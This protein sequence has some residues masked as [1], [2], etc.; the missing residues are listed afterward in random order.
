MAGLGP[1]ITL[2]KQ[3]FPPDLSPRYLQAALIPLGQTLEMAAG[4]MTS[5]SNSGER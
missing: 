2:L 5:G 3:F 1:V 4:M